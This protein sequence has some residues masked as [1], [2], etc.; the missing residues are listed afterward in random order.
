LGNPHSFIIRQ[1]ENIIAQPSLPADRKRAQAA[2]EFVGQLVRSNRG[3]SNRAERLG[4][5]ALL[6]SAPDVSLARKVLEALQNL[7]REPPRFFRRLVY[8]SPATM[9][10]GL[11]FL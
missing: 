8:L 4:E 6:R 2:E 3:I 11:W 10:W 9:A 5:D 7:F 1:D